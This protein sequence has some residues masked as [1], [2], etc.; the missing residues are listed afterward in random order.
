MYWYPK[1]KNNS[2]LTL[3]RLWA[4][5]LYDTVLPTATTCMEGS[6]MMARNSSTLSPPGGA[7]PGTFTHYIHYLLNVW[8]AGTEHRRYIQLNIFMAHI[9]GLKM[10]PLITTAQSSI[11]SVQNSSCKTV[12][13]INCVSFDEPW[14]N[15]EFAKRYKNLAVKPHLHL[16]QKF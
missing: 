6:S 11:I 9:A 5:Q 8:H 13:L 3:G 14:E 16:W 10:F 4:L 15:T 7:G 2:L 1:Y 12:N